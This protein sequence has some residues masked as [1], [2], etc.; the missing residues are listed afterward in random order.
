[1]PADVTSY[2]VLGLKPGADRDAIEKAYRRLIKLHHPDRAGGDGQ[3]AAEINRAYFELRGREQ[4]Q[5][6][7]REP[8]DFAEAIYMRRAGRTRVEPRPRRKLAWKSLALAGIAVAVLVWRSDLGAILGT[9][10]ADVSGAMEPGTGYLVAPAPAEG[11]DPLT[12]RLHSRAIRHSVRAARRMLASGNIE[13]AADLSRDCHRKMRSAPSAEQLDRCAAIDFTVV[14]MGH[15]EVLRDDGPFSA[16]AVTAREMSAAQLLSDNYPLIEKRFDK[17]RARVQVQLNPPKPPP[18]RPSPVSNGAEARP[19]T[20]A[21]A[22]DQAVRT[23]RPARLP[24]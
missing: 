8:A 4:L 14:A 6:A 2:A 19:E 11:P 21:G 20:S 12:G 5:A 3:R 23:E 15:N 10:G 1:M 7:E 24:D 17:V 22:A 18:P 9:L 16:S 13:R